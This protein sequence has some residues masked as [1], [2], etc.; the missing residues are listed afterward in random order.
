MGLF[1]YHCPP[2]VQSRLANRQLSPCPA[3]CKGSRKGRGGRLFNPF[4]ACG[5]GC[6]PQQTPRRGLHASSCEHPAYALSQRGYRQREAGRISS[7]VRVPVLGTG[8]FG[9]R[10][11][12][13]ALDSN[14][15]RKNPAEGDIP[16]EVCHHD[17][18]CPFIP[19]TW[20][21]RFRRSLAARVPGFVLPSLHCLWRNLCLTTNS[22][23]WLTPA[24][25]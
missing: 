3:R 10:C 23:L 15:P 8:D 21:P 19:L 18:A 9:F 5:L 25:A 14:E 17:Q 12:F 11:L 13:H 24:F 22:S 20:C 7:G 1:S 2:K 4:A 6:E 16:P